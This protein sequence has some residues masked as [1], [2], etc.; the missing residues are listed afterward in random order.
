MPSLF[1]SALGLSLILLTQALGLFGICSP[2]NSLKEGIPKSWLSTWKQGT[3]RSREERTAGKI[4]IRHEE[5]LS[6]LE[7]RCWKRS[8]RGPWKCLPVAL[9]R[10]CPSA[11]S[12]LSSGLLVSLALLLPPDEAHKGRLASSS[13][14]ATLTLGGCPYLASPPR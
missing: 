6:Q 1:Q 4:I 5:E 14:L 9:S 3:R 13:A 11:Y 10:L 2:A 8:F 7:R 12:V